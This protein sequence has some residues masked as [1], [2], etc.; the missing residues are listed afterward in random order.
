[1]ATA[2]RRSLRTRSAPPRADSPISYAHIARPI[3]EE[4]LSSSSDEHE[5][6]IEVLEAPPAMARTPEELTSPELWEIL[7]DQRAS[8]TF[9]DLGGEW[10]PAGIEVVATPSPSPPPL[11]LSGDLPL[12]V[13]RNMDLD[14]APPSDFLQSLNVSG[15][16]DREQAIRLIAE[17]RRLRGETI[18][19]STPA[20]SI[21]PT[22]EENP[23]TIHLLQSELNP[24]VYFV[25]IQT[26][27]AR[28]TFVQPLD[29][30][31]PDCTIITRLIAAGFPLGRTLRAITDPS[32]YLIGTADIPVDVEGDYMNR[33][34]GFRELGSWLTFESSPTLAALRP[35]SESLPRSNVLATY[36][37]DDNVPVYV[38]YIYHEAADMLYAGNPGAPQAAPASQ[39][40]PPIH[41]PMTSAPNVVTTYLRDTFP[42]HFQ[43]IAHAQATYA[44]AYQH[45]LVERYGM[46]V[47]HEAG[48][49]FGR[50]IVAGHTPS[51][52]EILPNDVAIAAGLPPATFATFRTEFVK[53]R[54]ARAL[55]K[56]YMQRVRDHGPVP[57]VTDENAVKFSALLPVLDAMLGD[58]ILDQRF[59]SDSTGSA[60]AEAV[61][62]GIG[63]FMVRINNAR[64]VLVRVLN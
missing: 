61:N 35:L 1:M 55:L 5:S 15:L 11:T 57:G 2:L 18:Q 40:A 28:R 13:S 45:C 9:P 43:Q 4:E 23:S 60:E 42:A 52:Q 25:G 26:P 22:V 32:S 12:D 36:N 59:L 27:T 44:T 20:N 19:V 64:T 41:A 47:C 48:I 6:D 33:H 31:R 10:L 29:L 56:R 16:D 39:Q 21:R 53:V 62:I 46:S 38:L 30:A 50:T 34:N 51:G 3:M 17:I 24:C 37:I 14:Q 7:Q 8:H 54:Q 63:P 49:T 58:Q